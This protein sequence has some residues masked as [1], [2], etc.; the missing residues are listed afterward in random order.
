MVNAGFVLAWLTEVLFGVALISKS[1]AVSTDNIRRT[2]LIDI[3]PPLNGF[4]VIVGDSHNW[5]LM[6]ERENILCGVNV[7]I[8]SDTKDYG[9]RIPRVS[10]ND[11]PYPNH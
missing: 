6:P 5:T 10:L 2:S 1:E 8:M 3:L 7:A 9:W 4:A 11:H